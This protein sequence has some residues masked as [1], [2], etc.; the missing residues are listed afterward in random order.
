MGQLDS[1][2]D[3]FERLLAVQG[4][5]GAYVES[6]EHEFDDFDVDDF[7]V[8]DEHLRHLGL[9]S[10][11]E[12]RILSN[13]ITYLVIFFFAAFSDLMVDSGARA[14]PLRAIQTHTSSFKR[15]QLLLIVPVVLKCRAILVLE[16]TK[17]RLF[18]NRIRI[19]DC[20]SHRHKAVNFVEHNLL[21]LRLLPHY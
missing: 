20:S 12:L 4:E 13:C 2:R 9:T 10:V 18:H 14:D 21:L 3:Q 8:D 1:L 5:V 6:F 7:I 19:I 11:I 15:C 16:V 17:D